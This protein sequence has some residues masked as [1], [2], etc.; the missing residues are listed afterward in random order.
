MPMPLANAAHRRAPSPR[1]AAR[2]GYA[3]VFVLILLL[4]VTLLATAIMQT[5]YH[6]GFTMTSSRLQ[7]EAALNS[8]AGAQEAIARIR[9]KAFNP[10][11][12]PRCNSADTCAPY[13]PVVYDDA[14]RY[15]VTVYRQ[16]RQPLSPSLNFTSNTNPTVVVSSVGRSFA[17]SGFLNPL[18]TALTEV[19]LQVPEA[20]SGFGSGTGGGNEKP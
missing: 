10:N 2:R 12:L 1:R 4:V 15:R 14:N 13:V 17:G 6:D 9:S 18:Y 11:N 8:V 20:G 19:E 3:L 5:A 7:S 16:N